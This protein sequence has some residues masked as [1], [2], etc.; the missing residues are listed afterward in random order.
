MADPVT[1]TMLALT[2]AGTVASAM[3]AQ[4]KARASAANANA[5]QQAAEYNANVARVNASQTLDAATQREQQQRTRNAMLAGRAQAAAAESGAGMDGSN[6]DLLRQNAVQ[7]ELDALNV[8]YA[9]Q[10]QAQGL[11]VQGAQMDYQAQAATMRAKQARDAGTIETVS[12]VLDGAS[13]MGSTYSKYGGGG[14]VK[15]TTQATY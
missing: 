3:A 6:L 4:Q 10:T 9:G 11:M 12:A 2:A 13:K 7:G 14:G 8:R 1:I 5:E 15:P